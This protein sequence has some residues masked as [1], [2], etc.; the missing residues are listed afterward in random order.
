MTTSVDPLLVA[1]GVRCGYA[2]RAVLEDVN[3]TVRPGEVVS[4]LGPNGSGKSTLLK[5]ISR[6][7][8]ALKGTVR[9]RGK[10]LASMSAR[11]IAQAVGYVPQVETPA[12]SFTVREIV[13]MGRLPHSDGLFETEEDMAAA[14]KAMDRARCMEFADR[15][16]TGLSGG[17]AQRAL[18]ARALAQE[19]GLLLLDEPT[20]HLDVKHQLAIAKL[21]RSLAE[22]GYAVVAAVHDLN[23]AAMVSE[24]AVVL[25]RGRIIHD[26]SLR[27]ALEQKTLD[28]AYG[29][30]FCLAE[31]VGDGWRVFPVAD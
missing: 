10:A 26:G 30:R 23:W 18:I 13:L 24:R 19:A 22:E 14:E 1:E 2:E 12:F 27:E 8:P 20:S 11:E 3:L 21:V 17:E 28:Q 5:T 9:L 25:S 29:V 16:I 15:P 7:I 6:A 4:L 31:G